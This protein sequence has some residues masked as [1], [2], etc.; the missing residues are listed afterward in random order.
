MTHDNVGNVR[1]A[2]KVGRGEGIVSVP[3]VGQRICGNAA[4]R[5]VTSVGHCTI[6]CQA[7]G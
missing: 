1:L 3:T 6:L 5:T 4:N 2:M 7:P